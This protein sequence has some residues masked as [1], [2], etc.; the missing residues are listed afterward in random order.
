GTTGAVAEKLGRRWIMCDCGK[1]AIYTIT[2]RML[3]LKKEIGNKGTD[4][5]HKPFILYNAGLYHDGKLLEQMQ[6]DEYKDF[7]LELFGCQ[8]RDHEINGLDFHGTL[9][10]ARNLSA[11]ADR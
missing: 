9:K 5:K 2:K 1:L 10:T 4:L 3:N 8:K 11:L 6:K 7:V